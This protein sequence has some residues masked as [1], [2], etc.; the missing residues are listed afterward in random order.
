MGAF[1]LWHWL[2]VFGLLVLL[3]KGGIKAFKRQPVV[4]I[5]CFIFL[6]PIFFLWCFV[7]LFTDPIVDD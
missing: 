5:L 1:S 4:A 3:L 6:I 7:E 2:I